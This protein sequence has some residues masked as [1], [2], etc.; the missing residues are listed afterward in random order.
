[1]R[2]KEYEESLVIFEKVNFR[3]G[4]SPLYNNPMGHREKPL[5]SAVLASS[6]HPMELLLSLTSY[7]VTQVSFATEQT[8][9]CFNNV[10]IAGRSGD[11]TTASP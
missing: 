4:N 2:G 6:N 9:G 5:L 7:V 3:K 10:I 8:V 1:M 11:A